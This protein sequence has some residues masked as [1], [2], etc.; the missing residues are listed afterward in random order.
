MG[1]KKKRERYI[2]ILYTDNKILLYGKVLIDPEFV[3]MIHLFFALVEFN[4]IFFYIKF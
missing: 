3:Q 1:G 4:F 2:Y